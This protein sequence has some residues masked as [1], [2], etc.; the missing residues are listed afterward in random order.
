MLRQLE[1][2]G[3]VSAIGVIALPNA[4]SVA[5]HEACGFVHAGTQR[6]IGYK[7]GRWHDVGFWDR[8]L[9]HREVAPA[10]PTAP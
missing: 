10:E 7:H 2:Q 6:A 1:A 8:D 4:A 5:L 9:A 3:Y